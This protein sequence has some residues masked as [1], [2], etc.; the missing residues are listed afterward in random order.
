MWLDLHL[1]IHRIYSVKNGLKVAWSAAETPLW[2]SSEHRKRA[3]VTE[4]L[5]M[6]A[7]LR[8]MLEDAGC[9]MVVGGRGRWGRSVCSWRAWNLFEEIVMWLPQEKHRLIIKP[10]AE[11]DKSEGLVGQGHCGLEDWKKELS[12]ETWDSRWI[13][14]VE[15]MKSGL[16]RGF[17]FHGGGQEAIPAWNRTI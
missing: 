8:W 11:C 7:T 1:K 3:A 12:M 17:P 13:P 4:C 2:T 16:P 5:L 6:V 10:R 15:S 9:V 14:E